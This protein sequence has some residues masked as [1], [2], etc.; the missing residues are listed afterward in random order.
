[1]KRLIATAAA[2]ML[3]SAALAISLGYQQMT[4]VS[5]ASAASL[6]SIPSNAASVLVAVEISGI[7]WRD[8]GTDPTST[9]GIPVSAGQSL[10]YGNEVARFRVIGQTAG[11]TINVTYYAGKGCAQ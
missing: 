3:S 6:P 10:C 7:R 1:M 11:A 2:C 4:S 5:T 8:D 9:V